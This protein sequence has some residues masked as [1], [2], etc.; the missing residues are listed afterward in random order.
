MSELVKKSTA[1]FIRLSARELSSAFLDGLM[2]MS[3][4]GSSAASV[5]TASAS[6]T[7]GVIHSLCV[8][9]SVMTS[10]CSFARLLKALTFSSRGALASNPVIGGEVVVVVDMVVVVV[11]VVVVVE[12]VVVE[13]AAKQNVFVGLLF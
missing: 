8:K 5:V 13:V 4:G 1:D 12:V 7:S 10:L 9:L 3:M 6:T 2:K 11:V